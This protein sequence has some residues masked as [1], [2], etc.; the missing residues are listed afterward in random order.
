M[1]NNAALWWVESGA[2]NGQ[3]STAVADTGNFASGEIVYFNVTPV[4]TSGGIIMTTE[5]NVRNSVPENPK[6][7][8][9]NNDVQDMGIY[10]VSVQITGVIKDVA[11][12]DSNTDI[13]KLM[14]W[15]NEAKTT[16]GYTQ[17]RFGLRLDVFDHFDLV[18]TANY[19]Y[20]LQNARF[21]RSPDLPGKVQVIL[22]LVVGG[23]V[24]T[25]LDLNYSGE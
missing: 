12:S 9:N 20:V 13:T 22:N 6:V 17:G 16:T 10:G 4:V 14:T 5:F 18:P 2:A 7:D 19:G 8:G 11:D 24:K 3:E 21:I 25:W 15:L 23:A 1:A